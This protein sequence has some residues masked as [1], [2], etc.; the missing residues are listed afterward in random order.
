MELIPLLGEK[1]ITFRRFDAQKF[2]LFAWMATLWAAA[3]AAAVIL[4]VHGYRVG[5]WWVLLGLAAIGAVAERQSVPITGNTEASVGFLPFV[6]TAV[7]FG[8]VA[9][10]FVGILAAFADFRRPYM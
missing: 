7:A 8:P 9:A 5:S 10:M 3:V 6:F 2:H 4:V 1:S